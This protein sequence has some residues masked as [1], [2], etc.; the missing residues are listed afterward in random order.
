MAWEKQWSSC[1]D[2]LLRIR[3]IVESKQRAHEKGRPTAGEKDVYHTYNSKMNMAMLTAATREAFQLSK[4]R[5]SSLSLM[6]EYDTFRPHHILHLRQESE[7][8]F[9]LSKRA[10]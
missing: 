3:Y 7:N 6:E 9:C 10:E 1:Q 2:C 5:Y 4:L 8:K